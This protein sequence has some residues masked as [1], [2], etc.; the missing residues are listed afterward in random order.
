MIYPFSG[1]WELYFLSSSLNWAFTYF[2]LHV[3]VNIKLCPMHICQLAKFLVGSI[4]KKTLIENFIYRYIPF[5]CQCRNHLNWNII[6]GN[7]FY[8]IWPF[9]PYIYTNM[10]LKINP[11]QWSLENISSYFH[12]NFVNALKYFTKKDTLNRQMFISMKKVITQIFYLFC[13]FS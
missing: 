10:F 12:M 8:I 13:I 6:I 5:L 11:N 7:F 9:E 1:T 4:F 3:L 2:P